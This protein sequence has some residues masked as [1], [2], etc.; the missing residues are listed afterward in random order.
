MSG[1]QKQRLALAAAVIHEPQLLFLDEPTSAVDPESRR[2]FWEKLFE[3]A[4]AGTTLL[5]STH[6]MDEAERCHRL[7]I[8]DQGRLAGDGTPAELTGGAAGRTFLVSQRDTRRVQ[9][10]LV[11]LAGVLSVAQIGATL[12]VLTDARMPASGD[13]G[14]CCASASRRPC[15]RVDPRG[16]IH[17]RR[18]QPRGRVRRGHPCGARAARAGGMNW[19]RLWAIVIKELRQLRRDRMT[20]AMVLGIPVVQLVLFG[21][22][23][24]M[25]IRGLDAGI[26]DQARTSRLARTGDGHA[27]HGRGHAGRARG[28]AGA[29]DDALRQGR[30]SVGIVM[31]HDFERRRAEGRAVAQILVDGSDTAVQSAAAQLAQVPISDS[32]AAGPA[33]A[34]RPARRRR[35]ASAWSPSTTPSGARR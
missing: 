22:A 12:R 35:A 13:P 18:T 10:A 30:I 4:D 1:G 6:Y 8:L 17:C 5:V 32:A 27:G 26:A 16:D 3:L 14:A 25:N 7:A 23:I 29:A 24:N 34:A 31:P 2:D 21:Y 19:R 15:A 11:G 28:Y 9:H 33:R 20:L